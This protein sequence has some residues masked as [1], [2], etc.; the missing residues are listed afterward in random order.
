MAN[1][2]YALLEVA[3]SSTTEEIKRAYARKRREFEVA[4]DEKSTALLLEVKKTLLDEKARAQYDF[5]Q[6]YGDEIADLI[7]RLNEARENEDWEESIQLLKRILVF[8][9]NSDFALN[10]LGICYLYNGQHR[11]AIRV[12]QRLTTQSPD[13]AVYWLNY[14]YTYAE[15]ASIAGNADGSGCVSV[16]CPECGTEKRLYIHRDYTELFCENCYE[17]YTVYS[18]DK[19]NL[20]REARNRFGIAAK[21]EPNNPDCCISIANTYIAEGDYHNALVWAEKAID[22]DGKA[23]LYDLDALFLICEIHGLA[24]NEN[25]VYATAKRISAL[26]DEESYKEYVA[27]RFGNIALE[28]LK[29]HSYKPAAIYFRC[30]LIVKPYDKDGM[31][32]HSYCERVAQAQEEFNCLAEDSQIIDPFRRRA[33]LQLSSIYEQDNIDFDEVA[34]DILRHL[35]IGYS[36]MSVL[37]AVQRMKST[38]KATYELDR[39][40]Y[41]SIN[42]ITCEAL[43]NANLSHNSNDTTPL[44]N[45][46]STNSSDDSSGCG[47]AI[48]GVLA[49]LGL[50][51]GGP[52]G[53]VIGVI[54]G[55][56]IAAAVNGK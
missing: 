7:E 52:I 44:Y 30:L 5:F 45:T 53:L 28:L 40:F 15:L 35:D 8:D 55:L 26:S 54:I 17:S 1:D 4:K 38:Y 18:D 42:Q 12:Y 29:L 37:A 6:Q 39:S 10:Q 27:T 51:T 3:P 2:Y 24:G 43:Q 36:F 48:V 34:N 41:D 21:L 23:D 46:T 56:A 31:E 16:Y 13:V 14:G 33:A 49:F 19:S 47:C 11:E 9:S 20:L 32:A 50:C 25:G 22:T